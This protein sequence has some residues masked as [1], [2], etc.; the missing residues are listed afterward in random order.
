M[1]NE[2]WAIAPEFFTE[3]Y[4]HIRGNIWQRKPQILEATQIEDTETVQAPTGP[5]R[6][7]AGDYKVTGKKGEQ[8]FVKPDIF[9][10]TYERVSKSMKDTIQYIEDNKD[11]YIE[12][13]KRNHIQK[14]LDQAGPGILRYLPRGMK[15]HNC[16]IHGIYGCHYTDQG[17][18]CPICS[19][20][21][22]TGNGVT[23]SD[24][25]LYI[26]LRDSMD[27]PHNPHS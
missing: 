20:T 7:D 5:I 26:D 4:T 19:S 15:L 22:S 18:C 8:W 10:K 12:D 3:A 25:E 11:A 27:P 16:D 2:Q 17:P 9:D 13:M 21:L 1:D 6:G 24:V 23:A 14:A